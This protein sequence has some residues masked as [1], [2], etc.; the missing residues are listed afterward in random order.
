MAGTMTH[1]KFMNDLSKK[2][3]FKGN[4][5]LFL[6]AGQGHDLLFFVRLKDFFNYSKRKEV[7]KIIAES[8]FKNLVLEWQKEILKNN[9]E[10]LKI[11]LYGYIAHHILDSYIHP[12]INNNCN[13]YFNKKDKDTWKNNGKHE[14][15]ESIIDV[16]VL[17]PYQFKV[18]KV[19]MDKSIEIAINRIFANV[20]GNYDVGSLMRDGLHNIPGFIKIY[21][22]DK[23][24]FKRIGYKIID[25]VTPRYAQKFT[26]LAFCYPKK[27]REEIYNNYLSEF[28]KLY[29]AALSKAAL[30]VL[31]VAESL[32]NKKIADIK[33]DKSAT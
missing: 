10:N 32:E 17:D 6:M 22:K 29:S 28:N 1:F 9:D 19:E 12:W 24:G 16:M 2:I 21:R 15:L 4:M 11:L 23:L 27:D 8:R 26:F 33:F 14:M 3:N 25:F 20:Y 7:A 5:N 18:P 13:C 31:E 30:L